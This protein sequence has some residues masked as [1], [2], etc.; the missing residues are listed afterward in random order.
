MNNNPVITDLM[1]ML[2]S[3]YSADQI[4]TFTNRLRADYSALYNCRELVLRSNKNQRCRFYTTEEPV[5][6]TS[7]TSR[8]PKAIGV[9]VML[10]PGTEGKFTV[11]RLVKN[12]HRTVIYPGKIAGLKIPGYFIGVE[13]IA[14]TNMVLPEAEHS[15]FLK[16]MLFNLAST[17]NRDELEDIVIKNLKKLQQA[18]SMNIFARAALTGELLK[19]LPA[20]SPLYGTMAAAA[21]RQLAAAAGNHLAKWYEPDAEI[22]YSEQFAALTEFFKQ[23]DVE[24][25][26][27]R[28]RFIRQ[29]YL[30]C[31]ERG[32][33][34][35]GIVSKVNKKSFA[36]H[37]FQGLSNPSEIWF[38]QAGD[39]QT[40]GAWLA[41]D[42]KPS[43]DGTWALPEGVNAVRGTLF[44]CPLDGRNTAELAAGIVKAAEKLGITQIP[45]PHSWP[46]NCR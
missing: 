20:I 30:L 13:N 15:V 40:P 27:K 22:K 16:S 14:M 26:Q 37:S 3:E 1:L 17:A 42:G 11:F 41:I 38:Y 43:A 19:I 12:N 28:C 6:E 23:L 4:K 32:V 29:L 39:A 36:I 34:P 10:L 18:Q 5:I 2:P 8:I 24:L 7:R 46:V 33:I 31:F 44:F 25:M 21:S 9:K 45:W 35:G